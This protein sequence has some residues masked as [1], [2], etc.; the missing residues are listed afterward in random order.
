[1][2]LEYLSILLLDSEHNISSY[3]SYIENGA[4]NIN[5]NW[6]KFWTYT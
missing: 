4:V 6:K 3:K 2:G 1:M 5:E